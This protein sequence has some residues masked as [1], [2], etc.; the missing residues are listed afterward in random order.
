[1][2]I[3]SKRLISLL[4]GVIIVLVYIIMSLSLMASH[5]LVDVLLIYLLSRVYVKCFDDD[6]Q[7][8]VYFYQKLLISMDNDN[9]LFLLLT[10]L[11]KRLIGAI[12]IFCNFTNMPN[13]N[14]F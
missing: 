12:M 8:Y 10:S 13:T 9:L 2:K 5:N 3:V 4:T 7:T 6:K 1:L 11:Y 14:T